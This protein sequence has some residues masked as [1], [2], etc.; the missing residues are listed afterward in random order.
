M[1]DDT[2]TSEEWRTIAEAPTYSVSNHGRVRRDVAI[3]NRPP[4]SI[5][6]LKIDKKGYACVGLYADG[7]VLHR[8]VHRLVCIAFHGPPPP[9]LQAAHWDGC[10]LNNSPSNL[11]WATPSENMYDQIRHGSHVDN[12]GERHGSAKLTE[13]A[14]RE[15]RSFP[16]RKLNPRAL[17]AKF[18]VPVSC[19]THARRRSPRAWKH[20]PFSA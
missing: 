10:K 15:I 7:R 20:I 8:T 11:R 2:Y 1:V 13:D 18:G 16:R 5:L 9:G 6:K 14:V 3:R 19:I 12:R 17:A 4:G